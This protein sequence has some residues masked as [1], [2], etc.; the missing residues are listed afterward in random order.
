M[1]ELNDSNHEHNEDGFSTNCVKIKYSVNV[2]GKRGL[3]GNYMELDAGFWLIK[4]CVCVF[5][6]MCMSGE[7]VCTDDILILYKNCH[8]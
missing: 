7:C 2:N 4:L 6:R 8:N 1:V 5:M 3:S